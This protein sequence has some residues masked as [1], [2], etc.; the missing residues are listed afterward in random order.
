MTIFPPKIQQDI[1]SA[2]QSRTVRAAVYARTSGYS[3]KNNYSINEQIACCR[4]YVEQRGWVI[5]YLFFDEAE[6]GSTIERPK[7]QLMLEKAKLR[8]FDIVLVWK[9]DRFCRSLV[10]LV[11][12]QRFLSEHGVSLASVTEL[13]DTT[14]SIGRFHFRTIGSVAE[15]ERELTGQ[16]AA[17]GLHALAKLHR[18]PNPFPPLGYDRLSDGKLKVNRKEAKLVRRIFILYIKERSMAHVAFLLRKDSLTKKGKK[19]TA[20]AV[21][22]ILSDELYIGIYNI[23]GVKDFVREYVIV[24]SEIFCQAQKIRLKNKGK[25][26][27]KPTVPADRKT[28]KINETFGKY[29]S[30]L[31]ETEEWQTQTH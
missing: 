17:M 11:N 12:I 13:L 16:R 4:T 24:E 5:N 10:D 27:S 29:L 6:G 28:E 22:A 26:A 18:W 23:A 2:N 9:L 14:T 8:C 19:W 31:K 25:G 15:L 1:E 21:Q 20:V 3:Q 7:F 30:I